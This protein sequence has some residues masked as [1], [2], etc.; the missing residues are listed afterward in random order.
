MQAESCLR[1]VAIRLRRHAFFPFRLGKTVFI[2]ARA[3]R[4]AD[5][6]R[7]LGM[8][9]DSTGR[10]IGR[11][12]LQQGNVLGFKYMFHPLTSVRYFEFPFVREC[13][14]THTA[15]CLDVS[16]PRLFSLHLAICSDAQ[17][18]MMNPDPS[19]IDE[20]DSI[21]R[22]LHISGITV[23]RAG[24]E[25]LESSEM[26]GRFD[27]IWSISVVEH[28][29]GQYSDSDAVRLMYRALNNGGRLILTVP[30]DRKFWTQ[31][32]D[33][34]QYGT[35]PQQPDGKYFFQR[36]YDAEAIRS[37]LSM[38]IGREPSR[39]RWYGELERGWFEQYSNN[40][41]KEGVFWAVR[42][43]EAMARNFRLFD[44]WDA[45]PGMG[46]CGLMYEK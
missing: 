13:L 10:R 39:I 9:F 43:S 31:S 16:S 34:Q 46:I 11:Q 7:A 19:D 1:Q 40:W 32:S 35:Q 44:A 45:M 15:S 6:A 23:C 25:R 3:R 26:S 29:A 14:P 41:Q 24:I 33:T 20:T 18:T 12:L 42:D 4:N 38:A 27:A 37:R 36:L 17:I 8:E 2:A 30:V 21:I 5:A 22:A 28:I